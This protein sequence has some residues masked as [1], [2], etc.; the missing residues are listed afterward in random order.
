MIDTHAH[1]NT[2]EFEQD[3]AEC[4]SRAKEHQLEHIIVIGMD[5][6]SNLKAIEI[7]EKYDFIYA[8]VGIHPGYVDDGS[9]DHLKALLK[10]PKVVAIGECG[11]DFYWTKDNME[12]QKEMFLNQIELAIETNYPLIIHT[13]KS[14]TEAYDMIKPFQGK[15]KGV[16][17]CFSSTISDAKKAI[18]LGFYIGIDGPVTYKKAQ[19]LVELVSEIDLK[20]ILIETDSPYLSPVPFRGKR[21]EP[22]YVRFVAEKIAEIKGISTEEVVKQTSL[23]AKLLF[24]IGGNL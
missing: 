1:L 10:H 18:D 13:R 14:F 20:H 5:E 22:S 21:N 12:K 8:S 3:L 19:D 16:F 2:I 11:L 24:N 6:K 7:A 15:V 23:N 9:T 4:I 17:H